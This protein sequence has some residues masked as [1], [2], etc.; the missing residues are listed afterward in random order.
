MSP[1]VRRYLKTAIG[2]LR[3]GVGLGLY[4]L[5][6]RELA[7]VWPGALPRGSGGP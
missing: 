5:A 4:M 1:L 7:G 3:F 6:R 2:F